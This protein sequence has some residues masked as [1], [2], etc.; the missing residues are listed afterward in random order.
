MAEIRRKPTKVGREKKK[1]KD[2]MLLKLT[3]K[4]NQR[5]E[6]VLP[7]LQIQAISFLPQS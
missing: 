7:V 3:C 5:K 1:I 4:L 2:L 6:L